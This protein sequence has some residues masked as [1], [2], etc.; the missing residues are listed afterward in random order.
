MRLAVLD[1]QK[2]VGCQSCMFACARK[3]GSAGLASSCIHVRS[4][5]GMENGFIVV[6]CRACEDPPCAKVCPTGALK[7]RKGGGVRLEASI[8]IGCGHCVDQCKIGAIQWDQ[9]NGKPMICIHCGY[10]VDYC[11]HGVLGVQKQKEARHA[12]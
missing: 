1:T 10:C 8:C 9:E 6:V 7:L 12:E 3:A 11:P 2:C 5:G 4:C